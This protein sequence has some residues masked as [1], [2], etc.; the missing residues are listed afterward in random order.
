MERVENVSFAGKPENA[1]KVVAIF[2]I[3]LLSLFGPFRHPTWTK[4]TGTPAVSFPGVSQRS[5]ILRIPHVA[6][7]IG[8][9]FGTGE[10]TDCS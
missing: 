2:G 6:F 10:F 7:F 8:K 5:R 9:H 1:P 3:F 4:L